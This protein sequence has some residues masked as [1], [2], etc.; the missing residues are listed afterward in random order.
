MKN[1]ATCAPSSQPAP[2]ID[3]DAPGIFES[4]RI[5]DDVVAC[6]QCR[7]TSRVARGLCL[8]CLLQEGLA[9]ESET[10][11]TL[12]A[13]L[14]EIDV[15]DADWRLGNYQILEEIG[16]GGMGVIYR[17]RQR[18]SRRIVALKRVL[19]YHADSRETL[20]R[21]RREAE[22]AASLDHPNI[23][24]IYEVGQSEDGLPFFSMKFAAGGSLVESRHPLR[25]D[26]RRSVALMAK[27]ARA[28]QYAHSRGILHRDLKPGNILLDGRGEPLV[29]D[30]GLAKWLDAASDLTRTLTIFGTPGY[31]APEQAQ[32]PAK[33]LTATAD[34][35]S[36]GAVLFDLFTGRP[37]FLGEHALAVIKQAAEKPAPKLRSLAPSADRDL[38]TICARCLEREAQARYRSAGDVAEDLERW[39]E[40]RPIIARPVLPPVRVWRWSKRNPWLAGS[41]AGCLLLGAAATIWQ[42]ESRHLSATVREQTLAQ[43]SIAVLPFLDLDNAKLDADFGSKVAKSFG[44]SL[45]RNGPA[46]VI[47]A[48]SP[49]GTQAFGN[50]SDI[51][52]ASRS[53]ATRAVLSGTHRKTARD[54]IR[55]SLRLTDGEGNVLLHRVELLPD[56]Q[57]IRQISEEEGG[58]IYSIL[59]EKNWDSLLS[60]RVDPAFRNDKARDF[61]LSG[62]ELMERQTAEDLRRAIECFRKAM[63]AEPRSIVARTDFARTITT[64]THF[65]FDAGLLAQ[66]G[67]AAQEAA[68]LDPLSAEPHRALAGVLVHTGRPADSLE[69][70]LRFVELNGPDVPAVVLA[71]NLWKALGRPDKALAWFTVMAQWQRRPADDVWLIGDCWAD[72]EDDSAA[73][74]IYRRVSELHPELPDGWIGLCRLR[75]LHRDFDSARALCAENQSRYNGFVYPQQI[76]AQVEFFSRNFREAEKLYREL[77]AK[78]PDGGG[79]FYGAVSYQSALGTLELAVGDRQNGKKLLAAARQAEMEALRSA[80]DHPEILYRLAAIEAATGQADESL[81]HLA[82]ARDVGWLDHRSMVLDPRFDRIQADQRFLSLVKEIE[83]RVHTMREKAHGSYG[84]P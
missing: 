65:Q 7:S 50:A 30:F 42:S 1:S 9:P 25:N 2:K 49:L 79:H 6:E 15:R 67:Q 66:A 29:S 33:N 51:K 4:V 27:V 19:S 38:E 78:D 34:I 68:K 41:V 53:Y 46:R 24:P 26:P 43:H 14:D 39:L 71:G 45:R 58:K 35:Y 10:D 59:S 21:F 47:S 69:E 40:G 3:M 52:T 62:R 32:G 72:L 64:R 31:I 20:A 75:L 55:V 63:E 60:S 12:A 83:N 16:R 76:A 81:K 56:S 84:A 80:P 13:V 18:H 8:N 77:S 44:Q 11:E 82:A 73:E 22:A 37:P 70:I 74:A 61:L 48:T 57:S 36:I 17:A 28:V 54:G 5:Q 23:L